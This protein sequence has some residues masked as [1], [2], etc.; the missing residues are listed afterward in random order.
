M[1]LYK[2]LFV[3]WRKDA[4]AGS[5]TGLMAIPLSV[6][7]CILSEYPIQVGLATVISA[8]I[9]SFLVYPFRA[10]NHNGV[11]GIAAGLAPALA[12]GV[13]TFGMEN[14]HFLIFLTALIQFLIWKLNW[15][16]YILQ[17]VPNYLVEGLLAGIG[18]KIALK[19]L[20]YTYLTTSLNHKST[21]TFDL[22]HGVIILL[23]IAS[24]LMFLY[25]Y[26][27]YKKTAPA[28]PYM[29]VI[30]VGIL[31]TFFIDLPRLEIPKHDFVLALPLPVMPIDPFLWV[32]MIGF[33]LMLASI[34]VIEQVMSNAAIEKMDPFE[35][36][37]DSNNSL[38]TIWIANMVSSFFGGMTNLDGL[39]K[40]TT[41]IVAGAVTKLSNLFTA[42]VIAI[43]VV[44]PELLNF[45]PEFS[46]GV[47]MIFSGLKMITGLEHILHHGRYAFLLSLFCG[48]LVFQLGI[49]EGLLLALIVHALI[50]SLF[51]K[52]DE[53]S[54]K[55]IIQKTLTHFKGD[56]VQKDLLEN[57]KGAG[58]PLLEKWYHS[59]NN[60]KLEEIVRL[61]ADGA[62]LLPILSDEIKDS[63]Q[64]I[65]E[66]FENFFE[67]DKL[68]VEVNAYE[69][70]DFG[71][72]RLNVGTYTFS[73]L[74]GQVP[75]FLRARFILAIKDEQIIE[76]HSSIL[77]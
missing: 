77:P 32:K 22:T 64:K 16:Q 4:L 59:F 29:S 56:R 73:W 11:P 13:H 67:K 60:Y 48:I 72:V 30:I 50:L 41:N 2:N 31:C 52:S 68:S 46:L 3:N 5:I 44:F 40:S 33:A 23:S 43:F 21:F 18:L 65:R 47:I 54:F 66:Y 74:D 51:L 45:L 75:Q 17:F 6:G 70:K 49:F 8:C 35:R 19:F 15:Q 53:D 34:D 61:Y 76:H 58:I 27:R 12:F 9:I 7:I 10:G 71:D 62:V 63:P 57:R 42:A 20:P 37:T 28:V 69:V 1:D 55:Q 24:F 36:K 25:L 26:H 38:L 14:M 39:A